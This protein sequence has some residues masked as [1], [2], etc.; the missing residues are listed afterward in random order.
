[1]PLRLL[2]PRVAPSAF[3]EP[4][5]CPNAKCGGKRFHLRHEVRKPV[6]DTVYRAVTARRYDC[7]RCGRTFRVY[8][9]EVRTG[10][11]SLD[12]PHALV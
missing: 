11:R 8:P 6:C 4:S 3:E 9:R 5:A 12:L 2:L 7:L 1:M 10:L